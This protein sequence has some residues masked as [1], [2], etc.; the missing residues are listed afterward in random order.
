V[1]F[2]C[3]SLKKVSLKI[4]SHMQWPI[5]YLLNKYVDLVFLYFFKIFHSSL[6]DSSPLWLESHWVWGLY[7]F[8][9]F[10]VLRGHIS[11][12]CIIFSKWCLNWNKSRKIKLR[13]KCVYFQFF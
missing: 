3:I 11:Y 10:Q 13:V 12:I 5:T 1:F 2:C 9:F 7:S 8:F 6:I 4:L